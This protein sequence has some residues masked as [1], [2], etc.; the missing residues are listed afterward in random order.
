MCPLFASRQP[1]IITTTV[2]FVPACVQ[3]SRMVI[4]SALLMLLWAVAFL[5][6]AM[7]YSD[8][9]VGLFSITASIGYFM[10]LQSVFRVLVFPV[11]ARAA[12]AATASTDSATRTRGYST[13]LSDGQV[14]SEGSAAASAKPLADNPLFKPGETRV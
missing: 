1:S 14:G 12:T 3:I 4:I 5:F 11:P 6:L 13:A 9:P 2:S 7:G 8:Y 10:M